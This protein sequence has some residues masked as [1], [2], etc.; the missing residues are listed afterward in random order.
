[1]KPKW[2]ETFFFDDIDDGDSIEFIMYNKL[3]FSSEEKLGSAIIVLDKLN[4]YNTG[5]W[6]VLHDE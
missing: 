3:L 5:D 6:F 2:N 4:N 1:M